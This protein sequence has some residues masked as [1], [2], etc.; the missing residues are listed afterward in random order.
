GLVPATNPWYGIFPTHQRD[1]ANLAD[2]DTPAT[3]AAG[4]RHPAGH[5]TVTDGVHL[6]GLYWLRLYSSIFSISHEVGRRMTKVCRN[7]N[8]ENINSY[9]LYRMMKKTLFSSK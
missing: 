4:G 7:E 9:R 1:Y 5:Y 6:H 8:I 2:G 3:T